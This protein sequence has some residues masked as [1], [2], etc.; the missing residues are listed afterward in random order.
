MSTI[1]IKVGLEALDKENYDTWRIHAKAYMIKNKLW[2]HVLE[3]PKADA[4]QAQLDADELAKSELMLLIAPSELRQVKNCKFAKDVWTTLESIYSSKGP[5][6]KATLLK[7]L[8]L[9][10]LEEGDNI[11]EHLT[12]MMNTVDTLKEMDID[13][14]SDLLSIMMLYSLSSDY[15]NFRTAIESQDSLPDPEKLKIKIIEETDARRRDVPS[16]S[17]SNSTE[18]AFYTFCKICKKKGH[19][20]SKC[21]SKNKN[22]SKK[23]NKP[24]NIYC[25]QREMNLH[26]C[27]FV[28]EKAKTSWILD[29]GCTSHMTFSDKPFTEIKNTS[30]TLR[31]ASEDQT[32][33]IRGS[34]PALIEIKEGKIAITDALYVPSLCANLLSVGKITDKG[35]TVLFT[36]EKAIIKDH[37]RKVQMQAIR[38]EDGLYYLKTENNN[39]SR[40]RANAAQTSGNDR[41]EDESTDIKQWH[42][43]MGHMNERDL[44]IALKN[45][46]LVGLHFDKNSSFGECEICIQGKLTRVPSK[47]CDKNVSRTTQRLEIV[48]S[49]VCGP[50]KQPSL[51]GNKY[52]VTFIDDY[53][54]YC[55]VYFIK[56]KNEVLQKFEEY[57]AEVENFTGNKIRCLQSDNGTEYRNQKFDTFLKKHGIARRL[58]APYTAHQNGIAERKNRTLVEKARCMMLESKAPMCLWAEAVYTANYLSNRS[59]NQNIDNQTPFERWVGRKPCVNHLYIFGAKAFVLKKGKYVSKFSSKALP[60]MFTGYS[61]VSKAFR[62]YVPSKKTTIIS[63]DVRIL[64]KMFYEDGQNSPNFLPNHG[65]NKQE[66]FYDFNEDDAHIDEINDAENLDDPNL[67]ESL[68]ESAEIEDNNIN[69]NESNEPAVD[70]SAESIDALVEVEERRT[71]NLRDRTHIE[72]PKALEDYVLA[73]MNPNDEEEPQTFQAAMNSKDKTK[74]L[75]AMQSEIESLNEMKTWELVDPPKNRKPLS[76][77]WVYKIKKNPDGT[78]ERYKARL[79]VKGFSQKPGIDY[80]K[81]FSPVARLSTI[82]AVLGI[83]AQENLALQQFDVSTAFLNGDVKEQ[84]FVKQPEGFSDGTKRVCELKRSLYGLKQAPLCWNVCI[85]EYLVSSGFKQS[86]KDPCLYLRDQVLIALYVDDGLVASIDEKSGREFLEQLRN[87]FKITTKPAS[88][89]LGLE[90]NKTSEGNITLSQKSYTEKI[91]EKFGMANCKSTPTPAVKLD[92][93]EEGNDD[94]DSSFPYRQ[95]VGALAYLMVATRP[96]ISYAVSV[97]SRNL[98]KPTNVDVMRVKRIFRYLK[99]TIDKG[100]V[101]AKSRDKKLICFS[102][103]DFGG[104]SSTG[105]STSGMVFLFSGP[106]MWKSQKQ[107]TVAISS[108]EAELVA[109]T[110]TAREALWLKELLK[111]IVGVTEK[112]TIYVDNESAIKLSENP[113]YEFHKRTKHIKIKNFFIRECLQNGD[114]ILKQVSTDLQLADMFTK[115]LFGPRLTMLSRRIGLQDLSKF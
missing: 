30:K 10:K 107:P 105:H 72:I 51:N 52:I 15:E 114:F 3:P 65:P 24:K 7:Q 33:E 73:A 99:G 6:R 93:D 17:H 50:F 68:Y 66:L 71:Y 56:Q 75:S 79:V 86:T 92:R 67:D 109:L 32:A 31:L 94:S 98:E 11:R 64:K 37:K 41:K 96:D 74:W 88:Y 60:G 77:K 19:D 26:N 106:I 62:I 23:N 97:A 57:K 54:R 40:H 110:E 49:D 78:I 1:R 46:N 84:I 18:E 9:A 63:K 43:K 34:G 13:I 35:L 108:T 36:K 100:L 112:P 90:I 16:T 14:N 25:K 12:K 45:E 53:S 69:S 87:R 70:A 2:N 103:A 38:D 28:N 76:C 39:V 20:T 47:P 111:E 104:D 81:T 83:A 21:W 5:A 55:R 42:R 89:F 80:Q 115:P 58:S 29:S 102:D 91:L 44:K 27:C 82:R 48:H 85:S 8:I 4:T 22:T 95:A 61:E 101:F 59:I 113:P